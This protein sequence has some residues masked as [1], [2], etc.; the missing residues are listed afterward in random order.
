MPTNKMALNPSPDS[1]TIP[2]LIR[3]RMMAAVRQ[4]GPVIRQRIRPH[5]RALIEQKTP[6]DPSSAGDKK[7]LLW[8]HTIC[9]TIETAVRREQRSFDWTRMPYSNGSIARF[10]SRGRF[11]EKSSFR[12]EDPCQARCQLQA[13][14]RSRAR[15][16]R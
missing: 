6:Q 2:R 12:D 7:T 4:S 5:L 3:I 16:S 15:A 9:P 8:G 1:R 14:M 13:R 11:R 10:V